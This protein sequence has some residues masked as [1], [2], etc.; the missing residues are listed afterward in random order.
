MD[1]DT[2]GIEP[3]FAIVKFKKLAGGGYFKIVNQS[4]HKALTKIGY[5][6]KQIEEI[7]KYCKGHGTLVGCPEINRA[8]LKVKGFTDEAVDVIEKQ[9]DN[10]FDLKFAF[11]KWTLGEDFCKKLGFSEQQLVDPNFN[12]LASLGFSRQ[13]IQQAND[14][15]CGTMTIEG[16]PG[17][18]DE[19]LSIFDCASK[20]GKYGQRFIAYEAHI[21]MMAAAQ[22]FISGA[23]SKTINMPNEASVE[24]VS[25]AYM[26]S[27]RLMIKANAL[28]RDGSKLSQPLNSTNDDADLA[29]EVLYND[30]EDTQT[31]GAQQLHQLVTQQAEIYGTL[32]PE[33]RRH[34]L[35]TKRNG[36]L[37]EA[38]VGGHKV[39]LR[40]GEYEDGTLG[41]IFIDMY[42]EGASF[43]GLMN[44][45]AVLTSKALQYGVPLEE[46]VDTFTFTRFEPAGSVQGHEAIKNSTSILDYVFRA[47]GYEYLGRQDFV[48]VKAVDE[49]KDAPTTAAAPEIIIGPSE[50]DAIAHLKSEYNASSTRNEEEPVAQMST[51]PL[52]THHSGATSA[53]SRYAEAKSK[54]YTGEQCT[55]CSSMRVKRN[56][57]CTVCEDCG[58]TSGC[59]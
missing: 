54:G 40:T 58:T 1:C 31:V 11:N 6:D 12:M 16:A 47:L 37:R 39:Y 32:A 21:R 35:P 45:F 9:L 7:E 10:V 29:E 30:I 13:D 56:G 2:T 24:D 51:P 25:K 26:E 34:K 43:K 19:H 18:K 38:V 17:L 46:L 8:S 55:A 15:V 22:P 14:Y 57:A 48:H 23:I 59:S 4:V 27:W 42:K 50:E 5:T 36:W 33:L 3:D 20:C 53:A 41:E 28:Y 49:P 52:A 44:C